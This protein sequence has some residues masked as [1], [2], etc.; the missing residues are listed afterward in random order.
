MHGT[1]LLP[2]LEPSTAIESSVS[3]QTLYSIIAVASAALRISN[4]YSLLDI[5]TLSNPLTLL[6]TL[7]STFFGHPA[8]SSISSDVVLTSVIFLL[9]I[10]LDA[11][12]TKSTAG[13]AVAIV[14][15]LLTPVLG[16]GCTGAIY[17][18]YREKRNL[19]LD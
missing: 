7:Y 6:E 5:S 19:K 4:Y 11:R 9:Y 14:A 3:Y 17:L 10:L 16:I 13:L 18:A 12:K 1:L 2:L 15:T 8:Q